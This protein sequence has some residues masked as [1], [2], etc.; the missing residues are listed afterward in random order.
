MVDIDHPN[1]VKISDYGVA[2]EEQIPYI[3]MEYLDGHF[4]DTVIASPKQ[5]HYREKVQ[6]IRQTA[7]ALDAVH[8]AGI[9]HRDVKPSNI[10]VDQ[11]LHVTLTDFGIARKSDSMLTH[12]GLFV[13]TPAYMSPEGCAS[14]KVDGRSDIYSLGVVAFELFLGMLPFYDNS[15]FEFMHMVQ[16]SRPPEPKKLDPD[17]PDFLQ[18]IL[19]RMMKKDPDSR[20]QT[21]RELEEDLDLFLNID[22]STAATTHYN[23]K[24]GTSSLIKKLKFHFLE[25]DWC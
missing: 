2:D 21:A 12:D 3:V 23:K 16:H 22:T 5:M 1:I 13:G 4:L 7:I 11:D 24:I 17:F 18:D 8:A 10:H 20:Y 25:T 6:I 14:P 9:T 15:L 19:A